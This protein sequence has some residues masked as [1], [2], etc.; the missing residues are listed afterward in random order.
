MLVG[1][2]AE[3]LDGLT[4]VLGSTEDQGVA[5]GRSTESKLIQGDGLTT[6]SGNAGTSGGGESQSGDGGLGERQKSVVIGDGA[7]NDDGALLALLVDVGN[8]SG[9][10]N[11]RAVD[12]GHKESSKDNLVEGGIGSAWGTFVSRSVQPPR[13]RQFPC[14]FFLSFFGSENL[15]ARKR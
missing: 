13:N 5:S 7:D 2:H 9:Q 8:N 14:F 12:L 15:R 4:A 6:G 11:G 3:V 1:S 10:R